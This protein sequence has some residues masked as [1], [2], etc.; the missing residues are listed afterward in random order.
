M[1]PHLSPILSTLLHLP[2]LHL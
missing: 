2:L 1:L